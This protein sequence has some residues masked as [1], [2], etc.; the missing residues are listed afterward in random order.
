MIVGPG[1]Y[2]WNRGY[3][4]METGGFCGSRVCHKNPRHVEGETKSIHASALFSQV[5][6][7]DLGAAKQQRV[8]EAFAEMGLAWHT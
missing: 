2:P 5:V 6:H 3:I 7:A 1:V 8:G 4:C